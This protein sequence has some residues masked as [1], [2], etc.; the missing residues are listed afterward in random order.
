MDSYRVQIDL[1]FD[2]FGLNRLMIGQVRRLRSA[3]DEQLGV[4]VDQH[5]TR[6][7]VEASSRWRVEDLRQ[8]IVATLQNRLMDARLSILQR[9]RGGGWQ[10]IDS[11]QFSAVGDQA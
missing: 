3:L 4:P 11:E 5:R 2:M 9:A 6:L 7:V 8:Q 1:G 10:V